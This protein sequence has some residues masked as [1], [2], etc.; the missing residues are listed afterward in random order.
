M[1]DNTNVTPEGLLQTTNQARKHDGDTPLTLNASLS[2]AAFLK[3]K[4]M[5]AKQYWAHNAPDGT[6]PWKWLGDVNY[7]YSEAGENLARG[8]HNDSTLVDA[9]LQSPSH[10][11]NVLKPTYTDVGFAVVD[12]TLD[13]KPTSLVVALYGRPAAIATVAG[14]QTKFIESSTAAMSPAAKVGVWLQT[15][16]PATLTS[17]FLL[18]FVAMIALAAQMYRKR[19]PKR[20]Q[21]TWYRHHGAYKAASLAVFAVVIVS[22]YSGGQI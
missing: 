12:G 9:W 22:L 1:G 21:Q 3:A 6:Q 17:V 15:I 18:M 13:G 2:K 5:F 20:L 10:R 7:N 8:F 11:A 4:D 16:T 19:L 14:A